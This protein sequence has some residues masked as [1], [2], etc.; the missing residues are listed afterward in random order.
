MSLSY[1]F[2]VVAVR[3]PSTHPPINGERTGE[4]ERYL[5]NYLT[6]IQRDNY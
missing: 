1:R 2:S 4:R 6:E 3:V 5:K